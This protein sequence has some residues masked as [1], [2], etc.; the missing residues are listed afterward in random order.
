MIIIKEDPKVVLKGQISQTKSEE[1]NL[2]QVKRR[3][4]EVR[5]QM[6]LEVN[7]NWKMRQT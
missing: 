6:I 5:N 4:T 2:L 3:I 1:T 7:W